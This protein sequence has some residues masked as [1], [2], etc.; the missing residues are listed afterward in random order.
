MI[1]TPIFAESIPAREKKTI[2]PPPY[3]SLVEGRVKRK[4]G[5]FFGLTNFGVN[6]TRL[7][8]GSISALLHHHSKQ[9]EFIY[10]LEETPTLTLGDQEFV[11]KPGDCCGFKAGNGLA[12]QLVNRSDEPVT[13]LEIGDRTAGDE[14]EYPNDDLKATQLPNG[15]WALTHKDGRPY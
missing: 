5:D 6:L 4:L 7:L 2:Y 8:P 10:I 11:L 14:A 12:H 9:D 3:A 15:E 1:Q 13:Y